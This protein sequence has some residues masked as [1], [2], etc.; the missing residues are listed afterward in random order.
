VPPRCPQERIPADDLVV[1]SHSHGLQPVLYAAKQGLKIDLLIDV[2]GPVRW[3]ML[4]IAGAAKKHIHRWVHIHAGHR[5]R[6]QWFGSLFDGHVGIVR[7]HPLA[8]ENLAIPEADH[9]QVMRDPRYQA[10]IR[11]VLEGRVHGE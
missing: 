3:D 10:L 5:D 1:I 2:C 7:K 11:G 8:D 6:W 4:P 9:S